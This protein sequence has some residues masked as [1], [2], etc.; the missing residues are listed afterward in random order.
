MKKKLLVCLTSICVTLMVGCSG[1]TS[2]ANKDMTTPT[3]EATKETTPEK[4]AETTPETTAEATPEETTE[5]DSEKTAKETETAKPTAKASDKD[6]A[7][8]KKPSA[9][10]S[11][12]SESDKD[13]NKISLDEA[14]KIALKKAGLSAK[15]GKWK[16]EEVDREDG[17]KVYDLEFIS[18]DLEYE[19]EID[20]QT[21]D[22]VDY[23][24]ESAND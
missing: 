23:K 18:G 3:D 2:D 4:T 22:V 17:R 9:N 5:A 14:K 24:K 1:Q 20:V 13:T 15:D 16:K 8:T 10:S 6:A 7:P 12:A 11:T 19:F 21:G